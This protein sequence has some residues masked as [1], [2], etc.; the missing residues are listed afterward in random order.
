MDLVTFYGGEKTKQELISSFNFSPYYQ[1]YYCGVDV[2]YT[3][4]GALKLSA[5]VY[6]TCAHP[7]KAWNKE[8]SHFD[9]A[10]LEVYLQV[11][12]KINVF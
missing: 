4:N 8:P 10:S 6:R 5:G 3:F 11:E 9:N 12:G 2:H 7:M 1:Q